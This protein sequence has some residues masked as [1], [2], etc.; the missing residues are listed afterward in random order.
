MS[1]FVIRKAALADVDVIKGL[2]D[3]HKHELGFV[4]RPALANSIDRG[5]VFIAE[6]GIGIVGFVEYHHRRDSQTTL[7]HIAVHSDHRRQ[8]IGRQL[9]DALIR[10][11]AQCN[12]RVIQLKCPVD[13][14]ANEFYE[15]LGFSQIDVQPGRNR[16]LAVW[17]LVLRPA[18]HKTD[19]ESE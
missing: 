18:I 17:R 6:N 7:Y 8:G 10:D 9:V 3:A 4:L 14:Q 19:K 15:R 1:D 12:K 11:A 13:L 16:D 5:E 2:A